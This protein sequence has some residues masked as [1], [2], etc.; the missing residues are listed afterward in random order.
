MDA[1]FVER[2]TLLFGRSALAQLE[3]SDS[4]GRLCLSRTCKPDREALDREMPQPGHRTV[5]APAPNVHVANVLASFP[6]VF[7]RRP[8]PDQAPFVSVGD[9]VTEGQILG[10][11]EAMKVV[12]RIEAGEA[13]RVSDIPV[14][15]GEV[16]EAG[17]VLFVITSDS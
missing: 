7:Y 9:L 8:A 14:K 12:N 16:V 10:V 3:Y 5:V 15:D 17:T 13:G 6:G 1:D 4:S 2:L 11:L